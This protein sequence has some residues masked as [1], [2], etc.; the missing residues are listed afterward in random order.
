MHKA[1]TKTTLQKPEQKLRFRSLNKNYA[2][3]ALTKTTLQ[4]P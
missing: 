4:K 2:S 3:E 1:L